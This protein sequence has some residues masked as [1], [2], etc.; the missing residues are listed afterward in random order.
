MCSR[1]ERGGRREDERDKEMAADCST[2]LMSTSRGRSCDSTRTRPL[3][4]TLMR[5]SPAKLLRPDWCLWRTCHRLI[6]SGN[7]H[8]PTR[9]RVATII[10]ESQSLVLVLSPF[11]MRAPW[12]GAAGRAFA[13]AP[14]REGRSNSCCRVAREPPRFRAW[15]FAWSIICRLCV[16]QSA[17]VEASTAAATGLQ[18]LTRSATAA[19]VPARRRH[20]DVLDSTTKSA[21]PVP[22]ADGPAPAPRPGEPDSPH[23]T[24]DWPPCARRNGHAHPPT[25]RSNRDAPA[26][27]CASVKANRRASLA[28]TERREPT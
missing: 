8:N 10:L 19:V 27:S 22:H 13:A 26:A 12:P 5:T 24:Q 1:S 15:L 4:H 2:G 3:C 28:E 21:A 20:A 7:R 23:P 16:D 14:T 17:T 25:R 11:P 6:G 9:E 18:S